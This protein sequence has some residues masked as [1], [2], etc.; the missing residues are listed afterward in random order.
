MIYRI[1]IIIPFF[2]VLQ[3]YEIISTGEIM[4][5]IKEQLGKV[6]TFLIILIP[7]FIVNAVFN[8]RY[9]WG[10]ISVIARVY[11]MVLSFYIIFIFSQISTDEYRLDF[12]NLYGRKGEYYLFAVLRIFPFLFIYCLT[13]IFTLINYINTADWPLDPFYRLLDGK[14]SNTIIYA[15]ILFVVLKQKKRPGISIPLFIACSALYFAADKILYSLFDPGLGVSII[16]MSKYFIFFFVLNYRFSRGRWALAESVLISL[17]SGALVYASVAVFFTLSFFMSPPGSSSNINSGE[18]LLKSGF[19]FPLDDVKKVLPEK[20]TLKDSRNIF[21][22]IEKYGRETGYTEDEWKKLIHRNRIERNEYI[23]S[24]LYRKNIKLNFEVLK[25]YAV[26]QLIVTPPDAA[27]LAEFTRY[28]GSYY[29][30]NKKEFFELYKSGNETIKII[31]LRSLAYS[32]D[33]DSLNFLINKLTS[34]ERLLAEA[35]YSSLRII[36]GKDIAAELNKEKYDIDVVLFFRD[37]A[38]EMKM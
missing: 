25:E 19:L 22:I 1:Y 17:F 12:F 23:F 21:R 4:H 32:K 28:F 37:Y 31:I 33:I 15:L 7:L 18:I 24:H 36:T 30:D 8:L 29:P 38:S 13:V 34:V 35:A 10:G 26:S 2:E 20:G 14:Y 5:V 16:K 6:S 3:N 11:I 9:D 27:G